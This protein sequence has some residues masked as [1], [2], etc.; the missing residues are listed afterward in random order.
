[1]K[2][3]ELLAAL[4]DS[5]VLPESTVLPVGDAATAASPEPAL[6]DETVAHSAESTSV[7][8]HAGSVDAGNKEW[9]A[10]LQEVEEEVHRQWDTES[11]QVHRSMGTESEG[12]HRPTGSESEEGIAGCKAK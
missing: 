3:G 1:M 8:E 11:E 2:C 9:K 12:V 6:V 5:T 7:G 4:D 10:L